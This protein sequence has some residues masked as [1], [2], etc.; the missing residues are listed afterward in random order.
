MREGEEMEQVTTPSTGIFKMGSQGL[1]SP[2]VAARRRRMEIR[3]LKVIANAGILSSEPVSKRS[4]PITAPST[5]VDGDEDM[6]PPEPDIDVVSRS[7]H[8]FPDSNG[9]GDPEEG[10]VADDC[11]PNFENKMLEPTPS[12]P[13]L[14]QDAET[15]SVD[16]SLVGYSSE[17]ENSMNMEIDPSFETCNPSIASDDSSLSAGEFFSGVSGSDNK[18]D[19]DNCAREVSQP[20]SVPPQLMLQDSVA[21]AED[22]C[23]DCVH[24][25]S[26]PESDVNAS[27]LAVLS[28]PSNSVWGE[29]ISCVVDSNRIPPWAYVS[30]RGRRPEME[31]AVAAVP[32]FLSLPCGVV[33]GCV[34]TGSHKSIESSALHFFGVYDGH[35]GLQ[36]A[37]FCRDRLHQALVEELEAVMNGKGGDCGES[38]WQSQWEKALDGCFKKVD[39][40]VG[41]GVYRRDGCEEEVSMDCCSEPV[42]PETVGSTAVVA[43]VGSCQIIIANCGDS[44]AVL[45]RRGRAIPLSVDHKVRLVFLEQ[46]L[47][48]PLVT[49]SSSFCLYSDRILLF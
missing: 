4:R 32:A 35:G 37:N 9:D 38:N 30:I 40:E 21:G 13:S 24:P 23:L 49:S 10:V 41:G 22:E 27:N 5:I 3:R 45:C 12:S 44:R 25:Q 31:D 18:S 19:T 47:C 16:G 7:F 48:S 46:L 42:A 34:A 29:K 14:Q 1:D 11:I 17:E 6:S 15:L 2:A 39:A 26:V 8:T 43:V 28:T 36:A 20:I 33:G